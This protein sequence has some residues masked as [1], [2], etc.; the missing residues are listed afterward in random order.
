MMPIQ[1]V[2]KSFS[3]LTN[4]EL[5][6][7]LAL[8]FRVFVEEQQCLYLDPDGLD[9]DA[10]HLMAMVDNQIVGYLR[11]LPVNEKNQLIFGRVLSNPDARG[12]GYGKSLMTELL[13]FC[14][15]HHPSQTVKC[16]AQAY[17]IEFYRGFGF[18]TVGKEYAEAGIPHIG[19][20]LVN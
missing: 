4:D 3:D 7:I 5:Y 9:K 13:N 17:L 10:M 20:V 14:K 6:D 11:L 19:M 16:S 18:E 12:K 15:T 2:W 1:F 8:R